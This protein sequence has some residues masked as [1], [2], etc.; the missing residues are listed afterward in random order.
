MG[1]QKFGGVLLAGQSSGT[2]TL[3]L[4]N[5]G[6]NWKSREGTRAVD[7]VKEE[8]GSLEWFRGMQGYLLR[9]K[10]RGGA[11]VKFDGLKEVDF[12]TVRDFVAES[13]K[14]TGGDG[15]RGVE[16]VM[17]KQL[18][19]G[20]SWG[21][22]QTVGAEM[23]MQEKEGNRE[24]FEIPLGD[25]SQVSMPSRNEVALE[26]HVD[27]T[28][29]PTDECLVEM[30]IAIPDIE[31]ASKLYDGIKAK[32]DTSAFAGES[33]ASFDEVPVILPR[34]RYDVDLYPS[35]LKLHGKS[36]DYKIL[37]NSI[38][39]LFLL[40]KPDEVHVDFVMSLDPPIRQG[41]TMY[42]HLIFHFL[43]ETAVE[44]VLKLSES[45]LKTKYDDKIHKR[46]EGE[47]WK[48]FS[49]VTRTLTGKPLHVPKTFSSAHGQ[50]AVRTAL[51]ANDG[52]IFLL[53]SSFFFVV[54]PPTYIRFDD[55]EEIEFKRMDM[56]KRFDMAV[57]TLS[58]NTF[59]F[60]NID[61][62]EFDN[63]HKFLKSKKIPLSGTREGPDSRGPPTQ[64]EVDM[65]EDSSE[66]EDF[67]P[68]K[69]QPKNARNEEDDDDG[70]PEPDDDELD[71]EME[72]EVASEEELK[73]KKKKKK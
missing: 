12:S 35:H 58:G 33:I 7:V 5:T 42:P 44:T 43:N 63:I 21:R 37:Y 1:V 4:G 65:D 15:G 36:A 23:L 50:R 10:L 52:H 16:L 72:E 27:D 66:D 31:E 46:E 57:T 68:S 49:K 22:A 34:G 55:I 13:W 53:E 41:N 30:R 20:W 73:P 54:K 11:S 60:S 24:M 17:G 25:V 64:L 9:C 8:I 61:K 26:F 18:T 2:G 48:V 40:P 28:M 39:R 29:G 51:G 45:D 47:L 6:L 38:S 19:S 32:A 3:M 70:E 71:A 62:V 69:P 14:G 59:L 67:D 56:E